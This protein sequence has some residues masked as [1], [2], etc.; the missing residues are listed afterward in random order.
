MTDSYCA[1]APKTLSGTVDHRLSPK[2]T[3]DPYTRVE[4]R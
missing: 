2:V 1:I 3:F 4:E